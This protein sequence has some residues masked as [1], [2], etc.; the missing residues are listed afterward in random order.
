MTPHTKLKPTDWVDAAMQALAEGGVEAVSVEGLARRLGVSK[1]SFYWHFT[2]RPALLEAVLALWEKEGTDD[3][4]VHALAIEDP[5]ARLRLLTEES[6][7]ATSRG[8]DV[9][10]T[11]MA[12]R[13]WAARDAQVGERFLHVERRRVEFLA[14]QIRELGY[15]AETALRLSKAM[16]LAVVGLFVERVSGS[17][18]ADESA[19]QLMIERL[20][21]E[22][23][24][25]E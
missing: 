9:A 22:A 4:I 18:F 5:V 14:A 11:E 19:L 23:P 13:S 8:V 16:N 15:D 7:E 6:L 17:E 10:R 2:G 12:I 1:G 24:R 21:T 25:L 3:L 20:I